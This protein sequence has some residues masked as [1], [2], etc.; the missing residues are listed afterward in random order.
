MGSRV[1]SP[2]IVR[3]GELWDLGSGNGF[4]GIVFSIL[5]EDVLVRCLDSDE[6]KIS[7]LRQL[8]LNLELNVKTT[9]L[10]LEEFDL[11]I[12]QAIARGFAPLGKFLGLGAGKFA[13]GSKVFQFKGP[14]WEKE[15][16]EGSELKSDW[17]IEPVGEYL[18]PAGADGIEEKRTILR[19]QR[20]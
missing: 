7:F 18:L 5:N 6:R 11:K 3:S 19:M 15:L 4:P 13:P 16:R 10:R 12:G 2:E 9:C 8:A 1:I 17:E 14:G 20:L